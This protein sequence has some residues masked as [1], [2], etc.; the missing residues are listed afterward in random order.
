MKGKI[1]LL[2][3]LGILGSIA[4]AAPVIVPMAKVAGGEVSAVLPNAETLQGLL[5]GQGVMIIGFL[6]KTIW[7]IF[8]NR[9]NEQ[10]KDLKDLKIAVQA[11]QAELKSLGRLPDEAEILDR[12]E[13]RVEYLVFKAVRDLEK[14]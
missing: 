12:L 3:W 5:I 14:R 11:I 2:L 9:S 7:Q 6:A 13:D 10:E 8:T 1:G 4:E